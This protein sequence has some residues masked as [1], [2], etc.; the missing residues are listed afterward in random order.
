MS[1]SLLPLFAFFLLALPT[2]ANEAPPSLKDKKRILFLGDSITHAGHYIVLLDAALQ[3][4][5]T[6][7]EFINLGLPSEGCTGL[8]E[9]AHPFPRPNIHERLERA[10]EQV[11]PDLVFACY[12]MNDGIYYPFSKERFAKY[13]AGI[14]LLFE[15]VAQYEAPLI[16]LT[17]PPFDP[18]PLKKRKKLLPATAEKFSW[19]QIYEHYDRDV[20]KPYGNWLKSIEEHVTM[21]VDLHEPI[22][23][24][25]NNKRKD[26]PNFAL[27]GDGVHLNQEGERII[28]DTIHRALIGKP[29]PEIPAKRV[30]LFS[31]RHKILHGSWLS[32]VGHKRPGMKAGLP[33]EEARKKAAALKP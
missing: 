2:S 6:E 20:I 28:A 3:G 1:R 25:V 9:P 8:S 19:M 22:T 24:Y 30:K 13:Q 12:G 31:Q 17:P 21:V 29:L 15:K 5:A 10:L 14:E 33:L 16:L 18:L 32:H 4:T 7:A 23:K 27:S 11:Q 26:N